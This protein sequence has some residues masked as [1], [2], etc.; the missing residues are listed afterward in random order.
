MSAVV[1]F[2]LDYFTQWHIFPSVRPETLLAR[3]L[4][5]YSG[6]IFAKVNSIDTFWKQR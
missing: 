6:Q 1:V 2:V 3:Y 5:K 4:E